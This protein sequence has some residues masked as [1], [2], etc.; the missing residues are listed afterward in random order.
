MQ[1]Y[2]QQYTLQQCQVL[3]SLI[4]PPQE[5]CCFKWFSVQQCVVH[6]QPEPADQARHSRDVTQLTAVP[7]TTRGTWHV[8]QVHRGDRPDECFDRLCSNVA[9]S[10]AGSCGLAV[11]S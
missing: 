1:G 8:A 10:S 4:L 7:C 11:D 5:C 6:S 2:I 3:I 9:E